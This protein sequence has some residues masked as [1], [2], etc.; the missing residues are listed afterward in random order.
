MLL[1]AV[2]P[3]LT[4]LGVSGALADPSLALISGSTTVASN[5]NWQSADAS[6][7]TATGAFALTGGSKDAA[8]V[9][10]LSGGAYSGV[11][12]AGGGSGVALL[13]LYD[14][15]SSSSSTLNII[16][17]STRAYVGTGEQVLIPGFVVS[18]TGSLKLLIRAAGPALTGLGVSGALGDPQLSLYSGSTVIATNDNWGTATNVADVR[19]A[20]TS[21]GAFAFTEGSKDAALLVTL[22][23]GAYTA[24]VS[25]VSGATGTALVEIYVVP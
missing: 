1:R 18:G 10:T 24:S 21:S 7:F 12:G 6:T 22:S 8:V 16:N 17:A 11:V 19:T 2:G 25:G 4:A 3:G 9:A 5:D 23:A 14:A 13:E 15:E 20:A